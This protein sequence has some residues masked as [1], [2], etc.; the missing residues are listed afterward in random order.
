MMNQQTLDKLHALR[1][2]GLAEAW[3]KQMENPEA[4]SLS[5]DERFSLLVDQHWTWREN[6]AMDRRL[7]RSKLD[8]DPCVEDIDLDRAGPIAR[9]ARPRIRRWL[10]DILYTRFVIQL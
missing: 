1:W 7:K 5:F 4:A 3:R 6:H 8:N 10:H 9:T 2:F